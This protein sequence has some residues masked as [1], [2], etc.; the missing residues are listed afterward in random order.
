MIPVS[1]MQDKGPK[2]FQA[3]DGRSVTELA[4]PQNKKNK[5]QLLK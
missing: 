4:G 2:K 3:T 1:I 5:F